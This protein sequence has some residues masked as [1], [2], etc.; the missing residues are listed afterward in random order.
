MPISSTGSML[1]RMAD[2][3]DLFWLPLGAGGRF[4]RLNGVVYERLLRR[5]PCDLYHAALEVTL[6]GER[7]V[8]EMAPVWNAGPGAHGGVVT[9][10]V[11]HAALGLFPLFRYEVRRWRGGFIPDIAEAVD[12]PQRLSDDAAAVQRVL[13]L[14]A[15]APPFVWHRE[16]WNSNSL[17]AWLLVKSGVGVGGVRLPANGRAPGWDAGVYVSSNPAIRRRATRIPSTPIV[18]K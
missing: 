12:S 15:E 6:D 10:P 4:V 13:D 8:I 7:T 2:G 17:V 5:S 14:C 18:S 3:V 11:G 1:E 16:R 9:G